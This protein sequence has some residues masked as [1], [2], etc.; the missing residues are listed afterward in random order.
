MGEKFAQFKTAR[1]CSISAN[2]SNT[3]TAGITGFRRANWR[4]P[5]GGAVGSGAAGARPG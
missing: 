5:L 1:L 4:L 2:L 3:M